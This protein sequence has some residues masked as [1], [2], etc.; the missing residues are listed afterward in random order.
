[1]HKRSSSHGNGEINCNNIDFFCT[2]ES[3]IQNFS[4]SLTYVY[5]NNKKKYLGTYVVGKADS[6]ASRLPGYSA[7]AEGLARGR[8]GLAL[9]PASADASAFLEWEIALRLYG[10]SGALAHYDQLAGHLGEDGARH[11]LAAALRTCRKL[12]M[13]LFVTGRQ[14]IRPRPDR[15]LSSRFRSRSCAPAPCAPPRESAP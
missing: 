7:L 14:V 12:R 6:Q 8:A 3:V 11:L 9:L 15:R 13:P 4:N 5:C 2:V 10:F 1:M